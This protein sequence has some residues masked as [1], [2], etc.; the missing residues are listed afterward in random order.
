MEISGLE[1]A[2]LIVSML[3]L[4]AVFFTKTKAHAHDTRIR[5]PSERNR[6][7]GS[8]RRPRV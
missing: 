3:I 8:P 4:G 1:I 5:R 7:D 6:D 2:F